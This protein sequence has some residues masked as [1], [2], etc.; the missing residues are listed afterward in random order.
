MGRLSTTECTYLPTSALTIMAVLSQSK[1]KPFIFRPTFN[2]DW[3][4]GPVNTTTSHVNM[5]SLAEEKIQMKGTVILLISD[6]R[7][8]EGTIGVWDYSQAFAK[9]QRFLADLTIS[10]NLVP[11][12]MIAK[13]D[14]KEFNVCSASH[15]EGYM[16]LSLENFKEF[17]FCPRTF[18]PHSKQLKGHN[19]LQAK[20]FV[21]PQP[22]TKH[23][24]E[25]ID[26]V[27][28]NIWKKGQVL[29]EEEAF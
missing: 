22:K 17:Q 3:E 23:D 20:S 13:G 10:Q 6:P 25:S 9:S 15:P 7:V 29:D 19:L 1:T 16:L 5:A 27:R 11:L 12:N 2:Y 4:K 24:E 8:C 21:L 14:S 28:V 18:S 26:Y